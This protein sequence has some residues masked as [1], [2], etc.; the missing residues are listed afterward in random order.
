M[1]ASTAAV[2][3]LSLTLGFVVSKSTACLQA[4]TF[5]TTLDWKPLSYAGQTFQNIESA[6][7]TVPLDWDGCASSPLILIAARV[8]SNSTN[9][10]GSLFIRFGGPGIVGFLHTLCL[11]VH[12]EHQE[13]WT[14][15]TLPDI[16]ANLHSEA[17]GRL[18]KRF[19]LIV[20]D[21]RGT[22]LD[23]PMSHS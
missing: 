19:D 4:S 5:N 8:P 1:P 22:G 12:A 21:N 10:I 6:N 15:S 17:W 16:A 13:Q 23:Y 18:Q 14:S 9:K 3:Q 11:L 2:S 7:I 20:L